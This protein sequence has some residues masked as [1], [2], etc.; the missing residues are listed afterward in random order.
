MAPHYHVSLV[1]CLERAPK[2]DLPENTNGPTLNRNEKQTSMGLQ[3]TCSSNL[4]LHPCLP[5]AV[6]QLPSTLCHHFQRRSESRKTNQSAA[7]QKVAIHDEILTP[8]GM[9]VGG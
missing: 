1:V 7:S 5:S 6:S 8:K 9:A 2:G 3:I 4:L